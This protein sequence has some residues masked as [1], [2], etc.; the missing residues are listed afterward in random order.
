MFSVREPLWSDR[1]A[2]P[3]FYSTQFSH[4]ISSSGKNKM[5]SPTLNQNEK[6]PNQRKTQTT[7]GE[8]Q[9]RK[10]RHAGNGFGPPLTGCDP[11]SNRHDLTPNPP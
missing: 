2:N 9:P 7:T 5:R 6:Y 8:L 10:T 4:D 11:T 1:G 3:P